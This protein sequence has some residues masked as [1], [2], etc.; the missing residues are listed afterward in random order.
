MIDA[1]K[2]YFCLK[3]I[4]IFEP[5]CNVRRAEL[6][7]VVDRKARLSRSIAQTQ[8]DCR[9]LVNQIEEAGGDRLRLIPVEIDKHTM[10]A[11]AKRRENARYPQTLRAAG[12]N[13]TVANQTEVDAIQSRLTSLQREIEARSVTLK[14]EHE[15]LVIDRGDARRICNEIQEEL[16]A[17]EQ[18]RENLPPG[19]AELR[20]AACARNSAL[21]LMTC[22][23]PAN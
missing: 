5:E 17:L 12:L 20:D 22:G 18:R 21:R 8:E 7:R 10:A 4:D 11:S 2:A 3:T 15:T 16:T 23:L 9:R 14:D 6:D 1:S 19:L 13:E